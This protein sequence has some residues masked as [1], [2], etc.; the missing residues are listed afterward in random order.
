MA[1]KRTADDTRLAVRYLDNDL[2]LS[3]SHAWTYVRLPLLSYEFQAYQT[4]EAFAE[5]IALALATLAPSST[6]AV[7]VHLRIVHRPLDVQ[8]WHDELG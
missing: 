8:Q 6:E 5:Q 7:D 3:A 2:V 4:R 1:R